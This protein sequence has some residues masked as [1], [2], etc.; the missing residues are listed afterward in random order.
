[1]RTQRFPQ[2]EV[3]HEDAD[4]I[5]INKPPGLLTSTVPHEKRPTAIAILRDRLARTEPAARVG[6]IHRLDKD[7]SG[8]LVFSKS[9]ACYRAL[10]EQFFHHSVK[11]VYAA[12][13]R[14][15]PNP[16]EG[17]IKSR[18]VELP[19][20]SVHSTRRSDAGEEAITH[21]KTIQPWKGFSMLRVTLETGKKHQIRV[22]LSER[23]H[24]ILNDPV[25]AKEKPSGQLM[26]CAIELQ[27]DH[28]RTGK[29]MKFVIDLPREMKKMLSA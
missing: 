26:L 28:P 7:A 1:M 15:I 4:L 14:G 6:V 24:A 3:V 25:Y 27:F 23:G 18:L 2:F 22:H 12:I 19:D 5:V 16:R 9:H 17:T 10:K 11:R 8:L 29:R 13:V 21:F 20:G